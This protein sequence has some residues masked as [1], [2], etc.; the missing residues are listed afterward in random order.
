MFKSSDCAE[1]VCG[2]AIESESKKLELPDFLISL[3]AV[4]C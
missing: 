4:F 2:K 3:T 1:E